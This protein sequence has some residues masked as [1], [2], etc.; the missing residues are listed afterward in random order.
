MSK[1]DKMFDELGYEIY[2]DDY[3]TIYYIKNEIEIRFNKLHKSW[4]YRST[5]DKI[6]VNTVEPIN[7]KM[8]E[9]GW[10]EWLYL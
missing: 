7:E 10:L 9:L 1:A 6:N 3:I 8:K 5:D 4:E 2:D